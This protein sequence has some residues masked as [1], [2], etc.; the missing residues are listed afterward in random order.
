MVKS[1]ARD[2][3]LR[4]WFFQGHVHVPKLKIPIHSGSSAVR[5]TGG[6]VVD[7]V[8]RFPVS[9]GI[10]FYRATYRELFCLIAFRRGL[11]EGTFP[12]FVLSIYNILY[13]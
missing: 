3:F 2:I 1:R 10:V 13:I 9:R 7:A 6:K 12:L 11:C 8:E 4:R 5:G